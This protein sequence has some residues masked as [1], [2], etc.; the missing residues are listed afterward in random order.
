MKLSGQVGIAKKSGEMKYM[1]WEHTI[2]IMKPEG[3][4]TLPEMMVMYENYENKVFGVASGYESTSLSGE[5]CVI[6]GG[7]N[8]DGK[9]CSIAKPTVKS[10]GNCYITVSGKNSINNET[11]SLG[12]F[13]FRIK[14]LP[15]A[16]VFI[17]GLPSGS[18]IST[19]PG[20][21][22][23]G[24][25]KDALLQIPSQVISW[26]L[27]IKGVPPLKGDGGSLSAAAINTLKTLK[28]GDP[29]MFDVQVL[30][31]G[32]TFPKTAAFTIK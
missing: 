11:K 5:G 20:I 28:S 8:F 9:P 4:V 21:L 18:K 13:A 15:R 10:P 16:D 23:S 7:S 6:S 14:P 17:G 3:S 24:F 2:K 27:K 25:P 32:T 26:S 29:V 22:S 31:K 30:Q 12:K 19:V 1:P